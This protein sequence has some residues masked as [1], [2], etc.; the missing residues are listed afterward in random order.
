MTDD[1]HSNF[2]LFLTITIHSVPVQSQ[3]AVWEDA[4][5]SPMI[6][7]IAELALLFLVLGSSLHAVL[8]S[9]AI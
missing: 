9:V 3:H 1:M 8:G 7:I 6:L 2:P 4:L 5:T